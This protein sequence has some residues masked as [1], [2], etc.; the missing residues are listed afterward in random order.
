[1]TTAVHTEAPSPV[2]EAVGVGEH[3]VEHGG[4]AEHEPGDHHEV[5]RSVTEV[6]DDHG[7]GNRDRDGGDRDHQPAPV[8]Q[9]RAQE[10]QQEQ[11]TDQQRPAQPLEGRLDEGRGTVE[12]GIDLHVAKARP[13]G[14]EGGLDAVGDLD[15]V[16]ARELLDNQ[17]QALLGPRADGVADQRLVVLDHRGHVAQRLRAGTGALAFQ[18]HLRQLSGRGDGLL[19]EDVESLVDGVDEPAGARAGRLKERERRDLEG[20][21]GR[22]DDLL[23]RCPV[24]AQLCGVDEDLELPV[25]EPPER[26]VGDAGDAHQPRGDD[27]AGEDGHLDRA[28]LLRGQLD[29]REPVVGGQGLDH[30]RQVG[31]LRQPGGADRLGQPLLHHL[32]GVEHVGAGLERHDDRG[33][34]WER[35]RLDLVEEGDAGQQVLLERDRDQLLDLFGGEPQGLGLHLDDR[36]VELRQD[37]HRRPAGLDDPEDHQAD[38]RGHDEAPEFEARSDDPTHHGWQAPP[39]TNAR[40][41]WVSHECPKHGRQ[42]AAGPSSIAVPDCVGGIRQAAYARRRV[43]VRSPRGGRCR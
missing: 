20:V 15:G 9:E 43:V 23:Q 38:R 3:V 11:P 7:R 4:Q 41:S 36:R 2:R 8:P 35:H 5:D 10:Q 18:R 31:H 25:P 21:P 14:V 28:Q 40:V 27:P 26:D 24:L 32:A 13:H 17:E 37:V 42:T 39:F 33:E 6:Q 29:H 19:V 1:L 34:P 12:G 16:G 30:L 22:L